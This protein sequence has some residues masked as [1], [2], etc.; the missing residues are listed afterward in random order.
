MFRALLYLL[1]LVFIISVVRMVLGVIAKGF[2]ELMGGGARQTSAGPRPPE[3]PMGGELKRDPVCGTFVPVATA[4]K[5]AGPGGETIY[6]CST[7]CRDRYK[8]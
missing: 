7:E 3:V 6:F 4:I 1:S 5:K 8:G 2:G